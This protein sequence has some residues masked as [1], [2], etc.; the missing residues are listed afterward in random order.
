MLGLILAAALTGG[1]CANPSIRS[2]VV[3]SVTTEGALNRYVVAIT[4][5]NR[6]GVRQPANLLQ[7]LDVLQDGEKVGRVGLQPLR[8]KQ[9]QKVTFLMVR[10]TDAGDGT[11]QLEFSL[12]F[13]G[14]SGNDVDCHAGTKTLSL[15]V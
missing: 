6:G 15:R 2:A 1:S 10:S 7:S 3:Q 4:V 14:R 12:D 11:T 8:P 5:E 13:N 9:S